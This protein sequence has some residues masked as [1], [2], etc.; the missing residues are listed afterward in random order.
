M[1]ALSTAGARLRQLSQRPH[2]WVRG[3]PP[4]SVSPC[5]LCGSE[6]GPVG[7]TKTEA[8][9]DADNMTASAQLRASRGVVGDHRNRVYRKLEIIRRAQIAGALTRLLEDSRD[10]QA[11]RSAAIS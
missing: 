3:T 7:N 8:P 5:P 9:V 11:N 4:P 10:E 6:S 1:G 2:P